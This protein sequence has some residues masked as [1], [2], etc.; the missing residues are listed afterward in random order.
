MLIARQKKERVQSR[1]PDR[2]LGKS[3]TL[4]NSMNK[5]QATVVLVLIRKRNCGGEG[6][7]GEGEL[8]KEHKAKQNRSAED[9][10]KSKYRCVKQSQFVVNIAIK[11]FITQ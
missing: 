6:W 8:G 1:K 9:S 3:F 7:H 11:I 5:G 2:R 10:T 4:R